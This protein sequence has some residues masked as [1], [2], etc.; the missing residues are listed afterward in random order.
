M[1]ARDAVEAVTPAV[2]QLDR[3]RTARW[4]G[5]AGPAARHIFLLGFPRSGTTLVEQVLGTIDGVATIEEEPT[6][7]LAAARYFSPAGIAALDALSETELAA[8]RADYWRRVDATGVDVAGNAFVDMDP[9]KAPLLPLIARLF[10]M[11]C[12]AAFG[13]HSPSAPLRS[14]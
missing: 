9:F 13:T 1:S 10:P 7:A 8:L 3:Q 5:E 4:Q 6:L 2:A 12:G 14:S 11:S